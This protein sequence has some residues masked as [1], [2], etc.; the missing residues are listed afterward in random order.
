MRE[1]KFRAWDKEYKEMWPWHD[2]EEGFL[3]VTELLKFDKE[4]R[5]ILM[6][7]TNLKDKNGQEIYEGD[8]V[9]WKQ[10]IYADCSKNEVEEI[11][12][13]V[14]G[15]IYYAE[16]LWLGIWTGNEG[17]MFIPG[18]VE[19]EELEVLGN[20]FENPEILEGFKDA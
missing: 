16:G 18:T 9:K 7:Y 19:S 14:I 13:A 8:I 2:K 4:N 12:D 10:I 15:E 6:Q 3:D 17:Y 20:K 5:Y 11:K 1:I